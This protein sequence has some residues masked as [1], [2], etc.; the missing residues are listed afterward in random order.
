MPFRTVLE[1]LVRIANEWF[2]SKFS[3]FSA[4]TT[5]QIYPKWSLRN[6]IPEVA[7]RQMKFLTVYVKRAINEHQQAG[8]KLG[9][10]C[11]GK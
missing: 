4:L 9:H 8:P 2:F 6:A 3:A 7:S 5:I 11:L 1:L 10:A